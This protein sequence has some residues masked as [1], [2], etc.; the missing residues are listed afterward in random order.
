MMSTKT[1]RDLN[2]RYK[3]YTAKVDFPT[4]DEENYEKCRVTIALL[5]SGIRQIKEGREHLQDLYN[6]IRDEYRNCKNK[7]ERKDLMLEIEQIEE[8][9]Q[10]LV[11]L[12]EAHNL[13]FML[14]T[15]LDDSKCARDGMDVKLGYTTQNSQRNETALQ[16]Q[17]EQITQNG[18]SEQTSTNNDPEDID[19][20]TR[21]SI[22]QNSGTNRSNQGPYRSIRPP[23]AT[24]PKFQGYAEEFSEYWAVFETLVHKCNDLDVMEKILLLK[25]SLRGRAQAAIKGIK[26]IPENYDWIIRTLQ[27]NYCNQPTNRSQIVQRLVNLKPAS[28]LADS[29]SAVFDQIQI[30]VNQMISAGYDVR[31]SCDPMWCETILAKFP[32]DVVKPVL[33]S[34]QT[35]ANQTIEDLLAQ[36][37]KEI[38]AKGYVENRLGHSISNKVSTSK[39]KYITQRPYTTQRPHVNEGCLFCHKGNHA[40]MT[41]RTVTDQD[42]RRKTLKDQNR[43][44]KCCSANHTSFDCLKP[45]CSNCGQKHHMSLC[46]KRDTNQQRFQNPSWNANQRN[47]IGQN[48]VRPTYQPNRDR[49]ISANQNDRRRPTT[50]QA[51]TSAR[52]MESPNS[53]NISASQLVLMTS[54]GY[55]WNFNTGEYEKVLF[56]FDSGAHKSVI[57]ESVADRFGLPRETTEIC[58]MS[59][60]GGHIETFMSHIVNMRVSTAF[61][62]EIEMKIQ[63]KPVITNSFPSV[64]LSSVDITFLKENNICLAN[65]KLRGEQ[66][67]P[68]ILVGLDLYHELV[69]SPAETIR[70]PTG[71][72]ITRTVFG[73]TVYGKGTTNALNTQNTTFFGLTAVHE[74]SEQ[75]I[76][77]NMFE[78]EGLG[79]SAL[80]CQEDDKIHK[81]LNEYSKKISFKSGCIT[82]PFPLKDNISLL[83]DNYAVAIRRL[84]SLQRTLQ[85]NSEQREWYCKILNNYESDGIIETFSTAEE[86]AVGTYYMPH[87]G[88]WKAGKKTPLRVVFDASSKK[89]GNLSLNDVIHKGE[90]FVKKIHDILISARCHK[91]VLLCDIEAAF[92]QI[93]LV[94]SNKDLCRFLW[95]RNVNLPPTKDNLVYYRFRRLPFG[96]TASPSI[97]NMCLA[98]FLNSQGSD[99]AQEI[100]KNLYVDNIMM[101]ADTIEEAL[102][103]YKASKNLFAQIGMNLREYVS[104]SAEVNT[105]IAACDK[106]DNGPFKLLGVSY[107]VNQDSFHVKTRFRNMNTITKRDIVSQINSVYDPIGLAGP[108]IVNLKSLMREVFDQKIDWK[109]PLKRSVCDRWNKLCDQVNNANISVPR[110]IPQLRGDK[111]RLWVF[112]DASSVAIAA[113]AYVQCLTSCSISTLISGKTKLTPKKCRQTIPRLELVGILMA[114]RLSKAVASNMNGHIEEINI[115]TDSEIALC[116]LKSSKKLPIFVSNQ[117]ERI[118]DIRE[119]LKSEAIPMQFFHVDTAHNPANVGTRGL[120]AEQIDKHDW[121]RGPRWLEHD[122]ETWPLKPIDYV[123]EVTTTDE[124]VEIVS[125]ALVSNNENQ[126]RHEKLVNLSRF[127]KLDKALRATALVGKIAKKWAIST[128]EKRA[129]TIRLETTQK[130]DASEEITSTDMEWAEQFLICQEQN[131]LKLEELQRRF[132]DKKIICDTNGILRHE[133]RLQ[134]AYMPFDTKSPIFIPKESD[135]VRL[136]LVKIHEDNAHCG[137]EHTLSILRQRF[138]VPRISSSFKK[139]LKNCTTCKRYQGLPLG[140]PN[141][142]PLPSDRVVVAK[143]FKN[144]GC[145]FM[146]PFTSKTQDKMYVCLY[147]CLTTR[148]VHLEVVENLSTAA[149]LSS[150]IRFISR[151]GVPSIMRSDCGTNL[152]NGE[153]IIDAMF[154]QDDDS[155]ASVMTYCSKERI[156]WIFNPPAS[157]WMGGVWERL[158]G[159]VKKALNK[160]IG[161]RKLTFADMC[162]VITRIEAILNTRPLTKCDPEDLTKIPLRPVDFL[163]GNVKFSIPDTNVDE[164]DPEF[165]PSFIQ[166]EKQ[167]LEALR[168]SEKIADK[169]WETWKIQYLVSLREIEKINYKQPRHTSRSIPEL[170]EIVLIEQDLIPRGNWPY[171]KVVELISSADNLIRSAKIL[172]PNHRTIQRPLNKIFPLEIRS[173][174]EN[175]KTNDVETIDKDLASTTSRRQLP[176]RAAK[177]RAY[178]VIRDFEESLESHP[179]ISCSARTSLSMIMVFCL[180]SPSICGNVSSNIQCSSGRVRIIP[181]GGPF[182]LCFNSDY[183]IP[184]ITER[185]LSFSLPI[186]PRNDKVHVHL[187]SLLSNKSEQFEMCDRPLFCDHQYF[188]SKSILGNPHCWPAGAIATIAALTYLAIMAL[189]S[190][191]CAVPS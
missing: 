56:F 160:S 161:R 4:I 164:R 131:H 60:M 114:T 86:Q 70:T 40:S 183:H 157:P 1:L 150:F 71:L 141:M 68:H 130:L 88:V 22:P 37:R 99:L 105:Q 12:G 185:N 2:L 178:D 62:E 133:S 59:G 147:T 155:G 48:N 23:Q 9:S 47:A 96:V 118:V 49:R 89:K 137:K 81:Y 34:G 24:L 101:T 129:S 61:G 13:I 26:L 182:Q 79:I 29:C 163:Q 3:E 44:W 152:K 103:K 191:L 100:A 85:Q 65:S 57:E 91:I 66:Q 156:K 175:R 138:W 28:N 132:H 95:L 78:L 176:S 45:D 112:A 16:N 6:E 108:L 184:A 7:S 179:Q 145:D 128:K 69:T 109:T 122:P 151:R 149:F 126:T 144:T 58:T 173:V 5:E 25:E 11:A 42:F 75:E 90:S 19:S 146:G 159:S 64:N 121:V 15:R 77:R 82:A 43:C 67:I 98:S 143:P 180:I 84:E 33:V 50:N 116:W 115:V 188:L 113:C 21:S 148:A 127:C 162:T 30:L 177:T 174:P 181:P 14:T 139:Y 186:S 18:D 123:E 31:K 170:G 167:A 140:A 41:C 73:P 63:T 189:I 142:P 125:T 171:G 55:I 120:T 117:R 35:I 38:A 111:M 54:E 106:L 94:E 169:F 119:Q 153:Q 20:S 107:D 93:R 136:I 53:T 134:N 8:E 97:L 172:M 187:R 110:S 10:L 39:E 165:D 83:E 76:L 104:N 92:T 124:G 32:Q 87:S 135:L 80:E 17:D 158:V 190:M 154:R 27:Q 52:V 166:T 102:Q 51:H 168:F 72:H 36:L 74:S 46:F